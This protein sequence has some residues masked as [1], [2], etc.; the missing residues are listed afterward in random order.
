MS[1]TTAGMVSAGG[2]IFFKNV[3]LEYQYQMLTNAHLIGLKYRF[4]F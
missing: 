3:G 1:Y 2:G 4:S